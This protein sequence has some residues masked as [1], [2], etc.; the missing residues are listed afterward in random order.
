MF[1]NRMFSGFWEHFMADGEYPIEAQQIKDAFK[2]S[3]LFIA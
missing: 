1:L 2:R 3:E